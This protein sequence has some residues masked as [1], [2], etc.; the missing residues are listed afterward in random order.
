MHEKSSG[1]RFPCFKPDWSVVR[2][3]PASRTTNKPGKKT[4]ERHRSAF[5]LDGKPSGGPMF[6][7]PCRPNRFA[8]QK[9][10]FLV[11]I[12]DW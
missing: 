10:M 3:W 8:I 7:Y 9:P 4:G 6:S 12:A 1:P 5:S 2:I 11:L